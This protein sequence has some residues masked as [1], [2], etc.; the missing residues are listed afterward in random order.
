MTAKNHTG[1]SKKVRE[2]AHVVMKFSNIL[3]YWKQPK[4]ANVCQEWCRHMANSFSL[5]PNLW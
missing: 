1:P 3:T 2:V 4:V 5:H